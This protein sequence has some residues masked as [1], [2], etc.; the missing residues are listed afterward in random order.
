MITTLADLLLQLKNKETELLKKYDMLKHGPMIGDMFEGLTRNILERAIFK[1]LDIR[2]VTGKIVND[3][4]QMSDQI[5][6]MI[7]E[8]AGERIPYTDHYLYNTVQVIAIVEVKKN[9]Y[10][11]EINDSYQ[12]LKSVIDVTVPTDV[13]LSMV[14]D[15]FRGVCKR[16]LPDHEK[17]EE[18]S[19]DEQYVYHTL[20]VEAL[21]P[22]RIVFGYYGYSSEY[23]LRGA[24]IKYLSENI[25]QDI[26]NPIKGFGPTRFPN[27]LICRNSSLIKFNG[28]PYPGELF[29]DGFLDIY[30]SRSG[31][32]ILLMLELIWTRLAYKYELPSSI[33]GEDLETEVF[34]P[35]LKCKVSTAGSSK[36][37]EYKYIELPEH[38]LM[39]SDET[40][41][42]EPWVLE[43]PE[44]IIVSELC[45]GVNISLND[46]DF[47]DFLEK[48]GHSI[49][50]FITRLNKMG[51]LYVDSKGNLELLTDELL[52]A[53]LPDGRFVAGENKTGRFERWIKKY[54]EERRKIR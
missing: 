33:F 18:L 39:T 6:C 41:S 15:A 47:I 25:S 34:N 53:I 22:I 14:R 36:G 9:L 23:K 21:L 17:L 7:V 16:E 5:D 26:N 28:M 4:N 20:I 49:D 45:N 24:F 50:G 12:N 29:E 2:V 8:G 11:Q 3:D 10:A 31:N 52:T 1:G 43:L 37:W 54:T 48:Y 13:S 42:W 44:H 27:L 32:P 35:F 51:I 38:E 46:Q 40:V 19:V 30:G